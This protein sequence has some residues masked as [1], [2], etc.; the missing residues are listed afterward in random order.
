MT[1]AFRRLPVLSLAFVLAA[2]TSAIAADLTGTWVGN[3][4][5]PDV[6]TIQ[7]TLVLTKADGGYAGVVS[8]S[9]SMIA[10]DTKVQD[11]KI[12]GDTLTCWFSLGDGSSVSMSLKIAGDTMTGGWQHSGGGT[13]SLSMERK[14]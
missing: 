6:G 2:A 4:D 8:D 12:D 3:T 14:K 7:V 5:V 9:A 11:L 13:G 10:P 1:T